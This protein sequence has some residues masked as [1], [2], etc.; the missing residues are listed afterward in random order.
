MNSC[1][2]REFVLEHTPEDMTVTVEAGMTLAALQN[3]LA[4]KKQWLPIDPPHAEKLSVGELL[5]TNASG[6]RRFGY[7]TVRD[8]VIGL[9]VALADGRIIKSGGKVVKNV[10]GYDLQKIFIGGQGTLG[11]IVE[12][13][14]KLRPISEAERFVQKRC[15]SLDDANVAIEAVIE[16]P[17]TPSVLDAHGGGEKVAGIFVVLGFDGTAEEVEW[18]LAKAKELGFTE[19]SSLD[20]EKQFWAE[21]NLSQNISVL[22]SKLIETI[23]GLKAPFVA[24][25]GNGIIFHRGG[26]EL[27]EPNLPVHLLQ[28]VKDTFDPKHIFPELPL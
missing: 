8:Y 9:K 26:L 16:S 18:Q 13:T 11:A 23:R 3:Q 2:T 10:A 22:P 17:L 20:Y 19:P 21:E 27:P 5:S 7:G 4:Q 14:F 6:P 1:M 24:R 25:A 15:D 28:R 12:A